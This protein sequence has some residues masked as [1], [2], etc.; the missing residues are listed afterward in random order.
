MIRP[1]A[2]ELRPAL[3]KGDYH[4]GTIFQ[5]LPFESLKGI[6]AILPRLCA[7]TAPSG[8]LQFYA[9]GAEGTVDHN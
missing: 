7:T 9:F 8:Y 1:K 5:N 6:K 2:I 3:Q 4:A